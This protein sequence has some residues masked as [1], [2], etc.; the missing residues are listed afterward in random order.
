MPKEDR[1][2][3]VAVEPEFSGVSGNEIR[4]AASAYQ[5]F[6][7]AVSAE[8]RAELMEQYGKFDI[9]V[10]GRTVRDRWN[11]LSEEEKAPYVEMERNDK[12][13]YAR[14][15]HQADVAAMQRREKLQ[16]ERDELYIDD[17]EDE[18]WEDEGPTGR[19]RITRKELK[20]KQR[21]KARK[22]AKAQKADNE[23]FNGDDDDDSDAES[24]FSV[25][26]EGSSEEKK[27]KKAP[28]RK[29]TQKQIEY[30]Q[31]VQEEKQEKE[32]YI[33]ERQQELRKERAAQA[34]RRLEFLLK[35]SNIFSHFGRVKED[36]AKY[37]INST[38]TTTKKGDAGVARRSEID[39]A[40]E[41]EEA[42]EHEATFL[43]KQPSTLG[44]GKMRDYQL[45]GL[46]WMIRLQENGV[47]GILADEM[48]L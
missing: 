11:D 34:K 12:A 19:K 3:W 21:K 18:V 35:Q 29:I 7:K 2:D 9:A 41:L 45:E 17:E 37:G 16:K 33:A 1:S 25:E 24:Y 36:T 39:E 4:K 26:S 40:E 47:N 5:F 10:F 38:V 13:R 23:E 42:D 44:H 30:R 6:Q 27:K 31:K 20:K 46:N 22:E 43:I 48:G 28:P 15:S 14:E 8:I 32:Q